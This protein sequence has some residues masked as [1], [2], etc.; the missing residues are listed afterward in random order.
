MFLRA[1]ASILSIFA[2]SSF[3]LAGQ[4]PTSVKEFG[5]VGDGTTDDT[6]AVQKALDSGKRIVFPEGTYLVTAQINVP[7]G[8][9]VLL[10]R[11]ST[12]RFECKAKN[13]SLLM[14]NNVKSVKIDGDL[15][16]LLGDLR[17]NPTGTHNA[18]TIVGSTSD[19]SIERLNVANFPD[20]T[21]RGGVSGDGIYIG[22]PLK[23]GTVP[24]HITISYCNFQHEGRN[25]IS[26]VAGAHIQI[27]HCHMSFSNF[28]GI[29]LEPNNDTDTEDDIKVLD[30][31][32]S[33]SR[34]GISAIKGSKNIVIQGNDV[35]IA[36]D[37]ETKPGDTNDFE[38]IHIDCAGPNVVVKE[39]KIRGGY[40]GISATH[41]G[42]Q[43]VDNEVTSA[44]RGIWVRFN[45]VTVDHNKIVD[46]W[47]E[48]IRVQGNNAK[49]TNNTI[50]DVGDQT[51]LFNAKVSQAA[52]IQ[53]NDGFSNG[54]IAGNTIKDTH[55]HGESRVLVR[56]PAAD[57]GG[58]TWKSDIKP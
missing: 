14:M 28:D 36:A 29:D 10:G 16:T 53:V 17:D 4:V 42:A 51:K 30:N 7:S 24:S 35:S 49:I 11:K 8:A 34:C 21:G 45:D 46:C 23:D 2:V 27:D 9:N 31:V 18:I 13:K 5:A 12:L 48:G 32:V 50:Q 58:T 55:P 37:S 20:D 52:A 25:Q 40:M 57:K 56:L 19:V 22:A 39:N 33:G 26:V 6:A 1:F 38:G 15:G 3:A 41:G 47:E 54:T 44:R 43:L